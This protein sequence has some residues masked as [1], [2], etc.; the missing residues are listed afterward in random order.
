MSDRELIKLA[1]IARENSYS[2]YSKFKVGAALLCEDGE[3][4][5]GTNIENCSFGA[6]NCAE[7]SALYSAISNGK[8]NFLKLAIVSDGGKICYPCGICR[9]VIQELMPN[10]EIICAQDEN[11]YEKYKSIDL[12]PKGFVL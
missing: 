7:R 6:T 1:M 3:V 9:Q 12:L 11:V 2:P 4:F 10:A 8:Q 5:L